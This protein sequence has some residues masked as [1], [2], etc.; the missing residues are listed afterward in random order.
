MSTPS[1]KDNPMAKEMLA[2]AAAQGAYLD[3]Q[4]GYAEYL[5]SLP[6]HVDDIE[7]DFG[8]DIYEKMMHD[9]A[10]SSAVNSLKTKVMA[11]GVRLT[12]RVSQPAAFNEDAKAQ[13]AFDRSEAIRGEVEDMLDGLQQP[14]EAILMEMMDCMVF[15]HML[16]EKVYEPRNG[17]LWL[18]T[19]RTKPRTR[20]AFVVDV[21][22]GLKGVVPAERA[23]GTF[24]EEDAKTAIIPREKLF[25]LSFGAKGGDPRGQSALRAAYNP[26][27]FEQKIW[28]DYL[29]YIKQFATPSL[30]GELP[31]NAQ[32]VATGQVDGDGNPITISPITAMVQTLSQF[33]NGA[34]LAI[35]YGAKVTPIEARGEGQ[36][37]INA[38][39]FNDRR[40]A[41]AIIMN[42]RSIMEAE[43]GSKADSDSSQDVV[44]ALIGYL[45]RMVETA[46]YR[47]V[48]FP[49]VAYNYGEAE[50]RRYAPVLTLADV[51]QEDMV[52]Y[53][54]AIADLQ[55]SGYL[56]ESQYPGT[57]AKMN[58]PERDMEAMRERRAQP[59]M[60]DFAA[61]PPVEG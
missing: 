22:M 50:A 55:S 23:L 31:E 30:V 38:F 33:Q 18:T 61:L 52:K 49:T 28:P 20:Y 10:V 9:S 13:A 2:S 19:L 45:K 21:F 29:K 42:A 39:N 14:I 34:V 27:H 46:F 36:T 1:P 54:Q 35:P 43:H 58:L 25:L 57:D 24:S 60:L 12:G 48:I 37:F 7:R 56:D 11:S 17:K 47:D 3:Y 44:E 6:R 15:G 32:N 51:Q 8:A 53:M 16:A 4:H 26:W 40:I 5:Q 41:Q 59:S